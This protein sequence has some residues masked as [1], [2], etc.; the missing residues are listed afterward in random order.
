MQ[1]SSPQEQQAGARLSDPARFRAFY[2]GAVRKVY[3]YMYDRCGGTAAVAEDLTQITFIAAVEAIRAGREI[4]HPNAWVMGI[5]RHK[6]VD[7]YRR[8]AREERRLR[9]VW[10]ADESAED[11]EL[12]HHADRQLMLEVMRTLPPAQQSALALRYLDDLPV[13][14][15]AAAMGRTPIAVQSLLARARDAFLRKYREALDA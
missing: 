1:S 7:H 10:S 8:R 14:E 9:L 11:P 3:A 15:V 2:E 4:E 6:L 5:A 12:I 13:A